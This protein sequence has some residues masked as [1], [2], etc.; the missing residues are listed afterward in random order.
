MQLLDKEGNIVMKL[1]LKVRALSSLLLLMM[2]FFVACAGPDIENVETSTAPVNI[3]TGA[4]VSDTPASTEPVPDL[5]VVN[6]TGQTITFLEREIEVGNNIDV[7]FT[8]IH[9]DIGTGDHMDQAT[10]NRNAAMTEKYGITIESL[11]IKNGNILKTFTASSDAGDK[12]CDVIH[13]NGQNTISLAVTGYLRNMNDLEYVDYDN[14]WWMS[15]VMESTS[16]SNINSFVIGYT[17][18]QALTA[19]TAVYFNK[20]LLNDLALEDAYTVVRDGRWTLDKMNEYCKAAVSNL[21][22]DE[23]MDVSDRYGL[24]FNSYAWA[25]FFYG[26]GLSIVGKDSSDIPVLKLTDQKIFDTLTKVIN[27]LSDDKVQACSAWLTFPNSMEDG[28]LGGHSMFYTQLMYTTLG[29]RASDMEFGILPVPKLDEA[30]EE[31]YSYIHNK[32]SYESVPK[33]NTD[34]E[35]TGILLEDMAYYSYKIVRPVFFDIM[36]DGKVARDEQSWEMLDLVYKNVYVCMLQPLG[37]AGLNVDSTIRGFI[38]QKTGSSAMSSSFK[39]NSSVWEKTIES[40]SDSFEK[41]MNS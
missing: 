14:P 12:I 30:Q 25:S 1:T 8:D 20:Q 34:L 31:Y 36:L 41:N 39:R 10:Y 35:R 19:V 5:P 29:M 16:I 9:G 38:N 40:I 15:K 3:T 17:N 2:L 37:S 23:S 4:V 6:Y 26:S 18:S 13:A 21:N 33:I 27:F 24:I 32:S 22:G 7:Y 11:R 28:F